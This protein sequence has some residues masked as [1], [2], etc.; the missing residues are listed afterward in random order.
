M[1]S[2]LCEMNLIRKIKKFIYSLK[3]NKVINTFKEKE[4]A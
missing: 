3:K 1:K 2:G 4:N